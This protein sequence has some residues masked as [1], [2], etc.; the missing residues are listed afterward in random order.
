MVLTRKRITFL[1]FFFYILNI[2]FIIEMII[3]EIYLCE[4]HESMDGE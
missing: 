3:W 4:G 1:I 2:Y